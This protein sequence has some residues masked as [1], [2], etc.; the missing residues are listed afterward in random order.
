MTKNVNTN[1]LLAGPRDKTNKAIHSDV[2]LDI[3]DPSTEII[4]VTARA[5]HVT[6]LVRMRMAACHIKAISN[7]EKCLRLECNLDFSTTYPDAVYNII[8]KSNIIKFKLP[9]TPIARKL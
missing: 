8:T 4:V 5:V 7:R 9:N 6:V 1:G 2:D 3:F